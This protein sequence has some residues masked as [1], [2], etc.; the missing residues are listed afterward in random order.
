[1]LTGQYSSLKNETMPLYVDHARLPYRRMLMSHLL[2]D[3]SE[4]LKQAE[5]L[6][7]LPTNSVQHLGT[8]KE[9]LDISESKRAIAINM[10]AIEVTSKHLILLI[11]KKEKDIRTMR[12]SK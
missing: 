12:Q 3:T 7:G 10:G 4:E 9:H 8:P 1:M 5:K 6:L 2:A 11:R